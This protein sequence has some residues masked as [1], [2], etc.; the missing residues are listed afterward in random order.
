MVPDDVA[1]TER[2]AQDRHGLGRHTAA[3]R[4]MLD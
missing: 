3:M 4:S 2:R 1:V